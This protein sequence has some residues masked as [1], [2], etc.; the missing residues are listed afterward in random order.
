MLKDLLIKCTNLIGRDDL[1]KEIKQAEH[2]D[3]IT[4]DDTKND[5][6][7]LLSYLN[8]SI[9][10][11][12]EYYFSIRQVENIS[13]DEN[14]KIS[15]TKLSNAPKKIFGI[16]NLNFFDIRYTVTATQI[17]VPEK[18]TE[19]VV[20]YSYIPNAVHDISDTFNMPKEIPEKIFIFS[21]VSEFLACKGKFEES[22]FYN[23]KFLYEIF[24][25]KSRKERRFK[26]TFCLW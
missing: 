11:I 1:S 21:T 24:K 22:E 25:I 4:S 2:I 13:S 19:Y 18:N 17:I 20:S 16:K 10:N 14:S 6:I 7:K 3:D 8:S 26:S 5:I 15:L 9:Q 23:D 12:F